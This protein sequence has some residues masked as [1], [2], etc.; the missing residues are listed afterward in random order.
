MTLIN[1]EVSLILTWPRE[2]LITSMGK[3]IKTNTRRDSSPSSATF[4]I[5]DTDVYVPVVTLSTEDGN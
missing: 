3:R 4:Q 5:K 1:C 2:C